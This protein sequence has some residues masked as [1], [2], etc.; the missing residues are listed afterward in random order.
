MLSAYACQ[1]KLCIANQKVDHKTN[2]ITAIAKLLDAL[3][4]K[5]CTTTM[6]ARGTE[7][8]QKNN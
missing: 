6:D 3:S 8:C 2:E 1:E 4:I 5:G 7:H